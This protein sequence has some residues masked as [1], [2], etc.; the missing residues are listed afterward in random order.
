MSHDHW[1]EGFGNDTIADYSK[2]EG[3]KIVISGHT[4]EVSEV[5]YGEDDGGAY[6]LIHVISQQGDGGAGG[7]NTATGAHDEDS[8]GTIKV[9]GDHVTLGDITVQRANVFD[10][11]DQLQQA[12]RLL[13]FN[14]GVQSFFSSTD[15]EEIVTAPDDI[16]TTD[17]VTATM[18]AQ[19]IRTG[20][21]RDEIRL[22]SDGGEPDPAQSG[23]A[24]RINPAV[25]QGQANDVASGGQGRDTFLFNLQINATA[26]VI[27]KHTRDD[28]SIDWR[29]VAGENGALHDHWVEGIGDDVITDYSNQDGDKIVIRGHTVEIAAI[30]YGEDGDGDYSLIQLRSQQGDNGGA[31]DEDLLGTIRVYGDLV[32][33]DDISV[34]SR[35][36]DGIDGYA[37]QSASAGVG[38]L[39]YGDNDANRLTGTAGSDIAHGKNG[40]DIIQGGEGDDFLFGDGHNDIVFGGEGN[41]WV[42]GGWGNDMLFGNEGDDT[43]VADSGY[44]DMFGG[45]G[46]DLFVFENGTRG[47]SIYD[48][49]DGSDLLDF[50]RNDSVN[51]M[52]DLSI[53]A[54]GGNFYGLS[55][56]NGDGRLVEIHVIGGSDF[57]I[58]QSDFVF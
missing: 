9:Y 20:A 2:A 27:A 29:R 39:V 57:T 21:G 11:V 42:E 51:G 50:S 38:N 30:T 58:D 13:D 12:D 45:G 5:T 19:V 28:G 1:V 54:L 3:D 4:V 52:D 46:S 55:Y 24:G 56:T 34:Q 33:A 31:H 36:F 7:A 15:G 26:A 47:A 48:W 14:G 25:P 10:G 8:L 41:D 43:L 32:T 6:S 18:G 37:D 22:T 35:V 40:A 49:E 44:D 17:Y 53:D 23:G 16:E